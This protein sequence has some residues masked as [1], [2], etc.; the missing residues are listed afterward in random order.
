[1]SHG[2]PARIGPR[3]NLRRSDMGLTQAALAKL[4][5]LSRVTINQVET[6]RLK[7]LSLTRTSKLLDALGLAIRVTQARPVDVTPRPGRSTALELAARSASVSYRNMLSPEALRHA[8]LTGQVPKPFVP[9][10][11]CFLDEA[12]TARLADVVEQLFQADAVPREQ[13]WRTMRA[14]AKQFQSNREMWR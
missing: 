10:L 14:L 12:P 11:S 1:M 13:S 2:H 6:A 3:V 4:C 7:D 9:H 5:G 8:L